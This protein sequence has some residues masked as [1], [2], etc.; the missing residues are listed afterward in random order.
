MR[1]YGYDGFPRK[2]LWYSGIDMVELAITG[3][4]IRTWPALQ[5]LFIE[6]LKKFIPEQARVWPYRC[7]D[8]NA[9]DRGI[10]VQSRSHNIIVFFDRRWQH[11]HRRPETARISITCPNKLLYHEHIDLILNIQNFL[12]ARRTRYLLS[13]VEFFWG[14]YA[15]K[16]FAEALRLIVPKWMKLRDAWFHDGFGRRVGFDLDSKSHYFNGRIQT[17]HIHSYSRRTYED[18]IFNKIE[19][20]VTRD[21]L[22]RNGLNRPAHLMSR[23][24]ELMSKSFS[25]RSFDMKKIRQLKRKLRALGEGSSFHRKPDHFFEQLLKEKST[26]E[27]CLALEELLKKVFTKPK[28]IQLLTVTKP[29]PKPV[30]YPALRGE[31]LTTTPS[32]SLLVTTPAEIIWAS[33]PVPLS[34]DYD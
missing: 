24:N 4:A 8:D 23:I 3:H 33:S 5:P 20:R 29:L 26:G 22:R 13:Y 21:Y 30:Q 6:W 27:M 34:Y 31:Q 19:L 18:M 1:V 12:E 14:T 2:D 32:P 28:I 7:A 25:L 10:Q 17:R 16:L 9:Y 11:D 15:D